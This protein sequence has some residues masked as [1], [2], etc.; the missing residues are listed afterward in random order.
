MY[1]EF[2]KNSMDWGSVGKFWQSLLEIVMWVY[3]AKK[4]QWIISYMSPLLPLV[5]S[6]LPQLLHSF[7]FFY[8]LLLLFFSPFTELTL[9][10]PLH[11]PFIFSIDYEF[12]PTQMLHFRLSFSRKIWILIKKINRDK[13]FFSFLKFI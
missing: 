12:F 5:P 7:S 3:N 4:N 11:L 1:F 2:D 8:F 13:F 6:L 9:W 10:P